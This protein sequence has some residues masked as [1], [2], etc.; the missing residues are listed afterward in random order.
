MEITELFEYHF[1]QCQDLELAEDNFREEIEGDPA[2]KKNYKE[3]CDEMG[4]TDRKGFRSYFIN[5]HDSDNIW[6]DM[7]PNR[8]ELEEY[9]F[10]MK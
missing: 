1:S 4:Y 10:G 5:K 2:L 6:D 8:E 9:D 3:W 7:Y